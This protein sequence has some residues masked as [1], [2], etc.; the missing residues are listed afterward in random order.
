MLLT[1][2]ILLIILCVIGGLSYFSYDIYNNMKIKQEKV[3][4]EEFKA[5]QERVKAEEFKA[6][7]ERVK[8]EELKRI[9]NSTFPVIPSPLGSIVMKDNGFS[10]LGFNNGLYDVTGAGVKNHYCRK[11]GTSPNIF[12]SC[13]TP[14]NEYKYNN[15]GQMQGF[16]Q[17]MLRVDGKD[18][19]CEAVNGNDVDPEMLCYRYNS[20]GDQWNYTDKVNVGKLSS[21]SAKTTVRQMLE[22]ECPIDANAGTKINVGN[23]AEREDYLFSGCKSANTCEGTMP[24]PVSSAIINKTEHCGAWHLDS[25]GYK[26]G[27]KWIKNA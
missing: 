23:N 19:L 3:K 27:G 21:I 18:T 26:W 10:P 14:E 17:Q 5:N 11:V 4:A 25:T 1:I 7:Q 20:G 13:G 12:V 6:N 15:Q 16:K 8:A 9:R 2:L 22:K 24:D